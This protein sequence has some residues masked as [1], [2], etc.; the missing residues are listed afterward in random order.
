LQTIR[1]DVEAFLAGAPRHVLP[2]P[3]TW[4]DGN[5]DGESRMRLP[6]SVDGEIGQFEIELIVAPNSE[7]PGLRIVLMCGRAFWRLCLNPEPH[8]NSLNRPIDLPPMV[9]GPHQHTWPDNRMFGAPGALPQ[10]LR[11]ARILPVEIDTNEKA[12]GWFLPQVNILPPTW[13]MPPWP[14][15]SLLL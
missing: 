14:R 2:V 7:S 4:G 3:G 8:T 15:R 6:I 11:N 12:F 13:E 10:K 5:R 9:D 1:E